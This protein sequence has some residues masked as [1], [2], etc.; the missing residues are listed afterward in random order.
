MSALTIPLSALGV[1]L[2]L[3][4]PEGPRSGT[5]SILREKVDA[6]GVVGADLAAQTD[7][8][9]AR[10]FLWQIL[11]PDAEGRFQ[12][13]RPDQVFRTGQAFRLGIEAQCDLWIYILNRDPEGREVVLLPERG[14][15][16]LLVRQGQTTVIPPDGQ[17]R[18]TDPPGIE[19]FRVLASPARLDWVN[20]R[21]LFALEGGEPLDGRARD[22]AEAQKEARTR[23]IADL[24][25][26]QARRRVVSEALGDV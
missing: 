22:R 24:R 18:F 13:A 9:V 7:W 25:R 4:V 16:H 26:R 3:G 12:P 20:P 21:E 2:A 5:R 23:A 6:R 15:E 14:E 8:S 10:G 17:F 1:A 11:L 19:T